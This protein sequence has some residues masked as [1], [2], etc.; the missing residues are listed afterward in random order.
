MEMCMRPLNSCPSLVLPGALREPGYNKGSKASKKSSQYTH[1]V[2]HHHHSCFPPSQG[3][4][5][6]QFIDGLT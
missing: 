2:M 5:Y 3:A 4:F 6:I 1:I